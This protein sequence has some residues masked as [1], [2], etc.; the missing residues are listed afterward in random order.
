MSKHVT[1]PMLQMNAMMFLQKM[2]HGGDT[3]VLDALKKNGEC[4][5]AVRGAMHR[6]MQ[7]VELQRLGQEM[8]RLLG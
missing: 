7:N 5:K 3:L 6:H 1:D 8:L 4:A 2:V